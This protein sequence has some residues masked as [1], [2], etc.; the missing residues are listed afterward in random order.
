[1]INI[2]KCQGTQ[3]GLKTWVPNMTPRLDACLALY[4]QMMCS[5]GKCKALSAQ[6][7]WWGAGVLESHGQSK[8]LEENVL[9]DFCLLH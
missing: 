8:D 7:P 9:Q 6:Q 1:M 2:L 5:H 4:L 3:G